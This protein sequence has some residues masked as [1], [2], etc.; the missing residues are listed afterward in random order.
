M[1]VIYSFG[2][3]SCDFTM[4]GGWGNYCYAVD[5]NGKRVVCGHPGEDQDIK[6]I[7]G[8]NYSDA[9]KAGVA[10]YADY[11]VCLECL[12]QFEL[13]LE[14]DQLA[15]PECGSQQVRALIQLTGH[16]CPKC[17]NGV[18]GPRSLC[19]WKLDPDWEQLPVPN[20]VK[21]ILDYFDRYE[22]SDSFKTLA[23]TVSA[24]GGDLWTASIFLLKWWEGEF[25]APDPEPKNFYPLNVQPGRAEGRT[26][27]SL[28]IALANSSEL[29]DLVVIEGDRWS[30][31][32]GVTDEVK[33]GIKNYVRKYRSHVA[34]C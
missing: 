11:C 34:M 8:L 14:K 15:C 25:G 23:D 6:R 5:A 17:K 2:C 29:A 20:I 22:V 30:F 31:A 3:D 4:P 18:F 26:T 32:S 7:T 33:R 19:P 21:E 16:Q 12:K 10:G 24:A 9:I 13:D 28:R 27:K 1:P